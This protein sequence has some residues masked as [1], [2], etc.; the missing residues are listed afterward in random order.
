MIP[1]HWHTRRHLHSLKQ[2][3]NA[4]KPRAG[5]PLEVMLK[6][7]LEGNLSHQSSKD[8]QEDLLL[9]YDA[10]QKIAAAIASLERYLNRC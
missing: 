8:M 6:D 2:I 3:N 1:T 7:A 4:L 5:S 9:L 10:Q